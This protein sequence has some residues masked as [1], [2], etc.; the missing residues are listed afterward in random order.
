MID[1]CGRHNFFQLFLWS[2]KHTIFE[3]GVVFI[4]KFSICKHFYLIFSV[5]IK[6]YPRISFKTPRHFVL[7]RQWKIVNLDEK[8]LFRQNR[9][10]AFCRRARA[11][12]NCPRPH[13][14]KCIKTGQKNSSFIGWGFFPKF[15]LRS[16]DEFF[17]QVFM[18]FR[19]MWSWT[20][21]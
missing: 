10:S 18:R 1:K 19:K 14:R 4:Q 9:K 2:L 16:K 17:Y 7:K 6:N 11:L 3:C 8:N 5:R 13:F 21:L 15:H 12:Q 20:I